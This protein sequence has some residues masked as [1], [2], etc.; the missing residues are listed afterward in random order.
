M[1]LITN[2][3]LVIDNEKFFETWIKNFM[4]NEITLSYHHMLED[5]ILRYYWVVEAYQVSLLTR[6]AVF[7]SM[8]LIKNSVLSMIKMGGLLQSSFSWFKN[9]L[10]R[11]VFDYCGLCLDIGQSIFFKLFLML[12]NWIKSSFRNLNY[13]K[14][15]IVKLTYCNSSLTVYY[16]AMML[17][18]KTSL[19]F[20]FD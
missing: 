6:F 8:N 7:V 3:I 1:L 12:A 14:V 10:H 17:A 16:T 18:M 4:F 11:E 19:L 2:N 15:F 20:I 13:F 9:T 5:C